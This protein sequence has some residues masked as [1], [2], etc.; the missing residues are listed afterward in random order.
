MESFQALR[1]LSLKNCQLCS[2]VFQGTSSNNFISGLNF[3]LLNF[4]FLTLLFA[5]PMFFKIPELT[6]AQLLQ[7]RLLLILISLVIYSALVIFRSNNASP[8]V[9]LFNLKNW[10]YLKVKVSWNEKEKHCFYFF[11]IYL[12]HFLY[13]KYIVFFFLINP[14]R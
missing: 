14:H 5:R 2:R 6:K 1:K 8:W 7:P 3:A 13:Q 11:Y 4:R 9:S 10:I 12:F